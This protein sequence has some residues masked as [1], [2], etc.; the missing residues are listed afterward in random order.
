[1]FCSFAHRRP[2]APGAKLTACVGSRF[3]QTKR[4]PQS[5]SGCIPSV[6]LRSPDDRLADSAFDDFHHGENSNMSQTRVLI[7]DDNEMF[8]IGKP[9][10]VMSLGAEV[11]FWLE[12]PG[13]ARGIQLV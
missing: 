10:N 4:K 11:R 3:R 7:V 2:Y 12:G 6:P 9:V 8:Y 1:M 5:L 13:S